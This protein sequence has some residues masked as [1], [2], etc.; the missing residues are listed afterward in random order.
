MVNRIR[1]DQINQGPNMPNS[2]NTLA[3]QV[4]KANQNKSVGHGFMI[5]HNESSV[6]MDLNRASIVAMQKEAL[7]K[8]AEQAAIRQQAKRIVEDSANRLEPVVADFTDQPLNQAQMQ[9]GL[10]S[11]EHDV[12]PIIYQS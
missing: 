12:T 3:D 5:G 1:S 9:N 8:E 10:H 2:S 7:A 4:Q 6:L 11:S